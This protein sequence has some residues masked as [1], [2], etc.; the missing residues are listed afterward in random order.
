MHDDTDFPIA[1][2]IGQLN[3]GKISP[4]E[5]ADRIQRLRDAASPP[6]R[7]P[8]AAFFAALSDDEREKAREVFRI[9]MEDSRD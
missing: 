5:A 8:P 9:L 7:M 3:A 2:I 1:P 4:T 6:I